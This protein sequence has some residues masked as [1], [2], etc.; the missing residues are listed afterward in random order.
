M[1]GGSDHIHNVFS[2]KAAIINVLS[3][4]AVGKKCMM[5]LCENRKNISEGIVSHVPDAMFAGFMSSSFRLVPM[6][7]S[8]RGV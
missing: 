6:T 4:V 2:S 3:E 7:V 8:I 1:S 5:F